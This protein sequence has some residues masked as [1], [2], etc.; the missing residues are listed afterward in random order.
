MPELWSAIT[1]SEIA[2]DSTKLAVAAVLSA[3][4]GLDRELKQRTMGLR[5]N[6][7]VGV[8]A[9]LFGILA[10]E[11]PDLVEARADIFQI[12]PTRVISGIINGIGFLGAG[13]IIQRRSE[14]RGGTTGATIWALGG[15]GL[16]CGFGLYLHAIVATVILFVVITVLGFFTHDH[17]RKPVGPDDELTTTHRER[18]P[19][20]P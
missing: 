16:A 15:I 7:L 18:A 5:T 9:A 6:M 3:I 8:G 1:N 11:I 10:L 2:T 4:I 17:E 13:A 14:I 20:R 12:D 19:N